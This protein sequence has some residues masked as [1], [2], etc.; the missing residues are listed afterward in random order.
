MIYLV[1][2]SNRLCDKTAVS[3]LVSYLRDFFELREML[4]YLIE[5]A[6]NEILGIEVDSVFYGLNRDKIHL[7]INAFEMGYSLAEDRFNRICKE[8]HIIDQL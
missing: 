5:E 3:S 6:K 1:I 4:I 7:I 8:S 2:K